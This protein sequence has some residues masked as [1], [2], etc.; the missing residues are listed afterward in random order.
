MSHL[1]LQSIYYK[2]YLKN[3]VNLLLYNK[4]IQ[5]SDNQSQKNF[6]SKNFKQLMKKNQKIKKLKIISKTWWINFKQ[7][8]SKNNMIATFSKSALI[9]KKY[10]FYKREC[11]QVKQCSQMKFKK[12]LPLSKEIHCQNQLKKVFKMSFLKKTILL[13]RKLKCQKKMTNR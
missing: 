11:L 6:Y 3:I 8:F 4:I 2:I 13:C 12:I 5:F 10:N 9:F 1:I 7:W